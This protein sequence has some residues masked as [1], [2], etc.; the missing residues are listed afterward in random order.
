MPGA[1]PD[2]LSS[3]GTF[4]YMRHKVFDLNGKELDLRVPH[5]YSP[6]SF[7]DD[8]WWHRTYW[9]IGTEMSSGYGRWPRVA[10]T[11]P[12]G[13]LLAF[14]EANV[15]G[16]GRN[17]YH[18]DG[19]HISLRNTHFL[20]YGASQKLKVKKAD[21]ETKKRQG[22]I[23][24]TQINYHWFQRAPLVA[25]A[26]VLADKTLFLAGPAYCNGDDLAGLEALEQN[27]DAVLLALSVEDGSMLSE[28]NLDSLPVFD[29]MAAANG[30]LYISTLNGK[31]LCIGKK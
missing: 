6:S 10:N 1:L 7:L 9:I 20:I 14:D 16:F 25:R 12:A 26:M 24:K 23:P 4:I 17:R 22:N 21:E 18:I 15:Y 31:V 11:V 2:I 30:R 13:R 29:G 3:N 28:F 19:S 8:S 5:M 27:S